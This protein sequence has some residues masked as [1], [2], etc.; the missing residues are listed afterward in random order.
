M[1]IS[2]PKSAHLREVL[3]FAFNW[4]KGATEAHRMLEEVHGDHALSK[5]QCYRWFKKFQSGDF[6]LDNEPRGKPHQK[7]EDAELQALLDNDSTQ[8]QEKLA[9]QLQVPHEL[10]ERQQERRLVTCEGLLARPEKKSFLH[11]IVASDEKSIHFSNP[12]RQK[13]W[14]LLGQ[15]PK[16][17]PRPNRLGKKRQCFAYDDTRTYRKCNN[18]PGV[19]LTP[20]YIFSCSA[21]AA[22]LQ[23]ID[24]DP[25]QQ[26]YTPKIVDIATVVKLVGKWTLTVENCDRWM[27]LSEVLIFLFSL[28]WESKVRLPFLLVLSFLVLDIRMQL[29]INVGDFGRYQ[30]L[31]CAFLVLP[32][33][34]FSS[35]VYFTQ[36]FIMAVPSHQCVLPEDYSNATF[37]A[38]QCHL[39]NLNDSSDPIPC[40]AGWHYDF[41]ELYPT[42]TT[43]LNWVCENNQLPYIAQT[44]FYVGTS[45]GVLV[46]GY[47]A[48]RYGRKPSILISYLIAFVGGVVTLFVTDFYSFLVVRFLV[49]TSIIPLSED[50]FILGLEYMGTKK[51]T[52]PIVFWSGAYIITSAIC[53]W[54]A[55]FLH[56]WKLLLLVTTIPLASFL[57]AGL[58]MPESASW[59]LTRGQVARTHAIFQQM[60]RINGTT[61]APESALMLNKAEEQTP[62]E[63]KVSFLDIFRTPRMRMRAIVLALAWFMTYSIYH[64]NTQNAANLGANFYDSYTYSALI[65]IPALLILFLGLDIVGRRWPMLVATLV[66]GLAGLVVYFLPPISHLP[67]SLIQRVAITLEY[68]ILMQYSA[69]VFPTV[70]RGRAVGFLRFMGTLGLYLSPSIVYLSL[71]NTNLPLVISGLQALLICG[72]SIFLP[73]TLHYNLPHTLAEGEAFGADQSILSLPRKPIHKSSIMSVP[74]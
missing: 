54:L 64:T 65:E 29:D 68:N 50:P 17:K 40:P 6:E 53:P 49:G 55:Y 42:I 41:Q 24:M 74:E 51:R 67:I 34:V 26:L 18:C 59:L 61:F 8:T 10:S 60:A 4:K 44:V 14:G 16:R 9:K 5:S 39:V 46:F 20:T 2:E 31:L 58:L 28:A 56:S 13:S 12:M 63:T 32:S 23:K 57:L 30:K 48:D 52:L 47:I 73:E 7:F 3:L 25:E 69:E 33:A 66:T 72:T 36:F 11:R 38:D 21:M 71:Q 27:A 19:E 43:D 15:F 1:V 22:A 35:L 45:I 70:M 37:K 62:E